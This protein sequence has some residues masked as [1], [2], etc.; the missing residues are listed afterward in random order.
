MWLPSRMG[1]RAQVLLPLLFRMEAVPWLLQALRHVYW[2]RLAQ[3]QEVRL[4]RKSWHRRHWLPQV[5]VKW[6]R[7]HWLPQVL[8]K[9][10]RTIRVGRWMPP[11]TLFPL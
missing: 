6:H 10:R 3:R 5:L 11:Q 1:W 9:W 4:W 8:V 7:R 2:N